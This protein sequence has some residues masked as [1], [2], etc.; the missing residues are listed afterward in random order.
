MSGQR[1]T[2]G[3]LRAA[4]GNGLENLARV[5]LV[6]YGVVHLLVAWLALQLVIA[7]VAGAHSP[8]L[9]RGWGSLVGLLVIS[10]GTGEVVRKNW[11]QGPS[12]W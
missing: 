5:G 7:A 3:T 1:S 11:T 9:S 2:G 10:L 6:S 8:D 12:P 4:D